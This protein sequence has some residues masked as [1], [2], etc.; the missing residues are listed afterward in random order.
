VAQIGSQAW[1]I[2]RNAWLSAGFPT[3]VPGVTIDRQ[4]GSS[5]QAVQFAAASVKAGDYDVAV[6]GGV[7]VMSKVP[8]NSS[9]VEGAKL[10][11][12]YPFDG[13]GWTDRFGEEEIHQLRGGDLIADRWGISDE[14]M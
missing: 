8:L 6:V 9:G 2:A 13:K 14:E 7:E 4:C 10:G 12:G 1:N 3:S 11:Y 5:Q